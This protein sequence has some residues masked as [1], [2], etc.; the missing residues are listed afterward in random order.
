MF[1]CADPTERLDA[2]S[3]AEASRLAPDRGRAIE[4]DPLVNRT[5]ADFLVRAPGVF[6]DER[7]GLTRVSIRGQAPLYVFDGVPI[8]RSYAQA[9]AL[10]VP[11]DVESVEVLTG[12]E[13]TTLYGQR[14][15]GGAVVVTTH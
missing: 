4:V 15:A 10:F 3:P 11:T 5:L 6:V 12:I 1:G 2:N 7:G 8:G 9:N 14:G 13:A